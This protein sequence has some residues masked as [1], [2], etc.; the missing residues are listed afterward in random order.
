[1]FAATLARLMQEN[2]MNQVT[3]AERA[4][5][6][7]SRINNY[8][9]GRYRTVTKQHAD[10]LA[11]AFGGGQSGAALIEA[12]LLDLVSEECRGW[13]EVRYPGMPTGSKWLFPV[14]GLNRD[15]ASKFT[16][17]YRFCVSSAVVRRRTKEWIA[18]MRE[19]CR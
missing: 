12:Y 19:T 7:V 2:A 6:A 11:T 18:I 4:G 8:L 1:L 10:A 16:K 3:V 15:F 17:L 13:I 14:K 5:I 9:H